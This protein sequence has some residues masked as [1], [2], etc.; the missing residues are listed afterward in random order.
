MFIDAYQN[1]HIYGNNILE[2]YNINEL[3]II[4]I[5][6]PFEI[7]ICK[8]PHAL[9]IPMN[10][11]LQVPESFLKKDELY[12]I[13]CHTG[14]RSYYVVDT[15][16]QIGYNVVNIIGGISSIEKYNVPY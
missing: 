11:L 15:L 13:I 12:F 4:D 5:R 3:N 14:Q 7:E 9:F 2:E 10:T 8:L 1:K 6:E 16:R